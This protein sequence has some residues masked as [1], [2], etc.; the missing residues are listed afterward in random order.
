M[1][2]TWIIIERFGGLE[3]AIICTNEDG[4]NRLFHSEK[5]AEGWAKDNCQDGQVVKLI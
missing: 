5:D 3:S 4:E 2:E 1:G